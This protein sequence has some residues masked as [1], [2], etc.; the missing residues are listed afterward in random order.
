MACAVAGEIGDDAPF[1]ARRALAAVL[2]VWLEGHPKGHHPDGSLCP[3]T[4]CSVVRGMASESTQQA[5]ATAPALNL[6][7]RWALF[8]S[9]KGG[10]SLSI[11]QIWGEGP[12]GICAVPKVPGDRWADWERSLDARQVQTLKRLLRVGLR[13]GQKGIR[14]GASGP[15]PVEDLRLNAGRAFGWPCWPSNACEVTPLEDGGIRIQGHG[16]GHNAGL[17]L[18]A[19]AMRAQEGW[20]AEAILEEAFGVG[21]LK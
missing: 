12:D 17:C 15:Y 3:L 11:R 20:K 1:E 13:P 8:T 19:A 16:W 2:K 21:V 10:V 14:L 9:S 4:H 6:D 5:A 18:A 7:P